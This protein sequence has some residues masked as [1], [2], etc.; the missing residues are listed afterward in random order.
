[1]VEGVDSMLSVTR[2]GASPS[3]LRHRILIPACAG[4]SPSA[5]AKFFVLEIVS[6]I[7]N[8]NG[9]SFTGL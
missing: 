4:S 9:S 6:L 7:V 8:F 3:W 2:V 1:M 5:P